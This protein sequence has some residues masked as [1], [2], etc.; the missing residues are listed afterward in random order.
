M[1]KLE[2]LLKLSE[3]KG[4]MLAAESMHVPMSMVEDLIEELQDDDDETCKCT[5]DYVCMAC[6]DEGACHCDSIDPTHVCKPCPG[7]GCP[8]HDRCH[9]C[10]QF[11]DN[12]LY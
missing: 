3:I 8:S 9:D 4:A 10:R 12:T 1:I 6:R 5:A 2:T 7:C 11:H